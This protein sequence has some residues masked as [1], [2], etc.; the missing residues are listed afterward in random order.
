MSRWYA[1]GRSEARL[2]GMELD[3]SVLIAWET[4]GFAA[5]QVRAPRRPAGELQTFAG[6][7]A[8]AALVHRTARALRSALR[9]SLPAEPGFDLDARPDSHASGTHRLVVTLRPPRGEPNPDPDL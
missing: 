9:A 3:G 1:P 8:D 4:D 5:I 7:V 2:P 6:A